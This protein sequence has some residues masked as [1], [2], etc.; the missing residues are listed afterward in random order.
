M[1]TLLRL[2]GLRFTTGHAL[3]AAALIPACLAVFMQLGRMWIGVTVAVIIAMAALLTIRGRRLT[4]WIAALFSWRRRHRQVPNVPSEPAVGATVIPGDHVAVRWQGDH[5]V[6][7]IE[8][9]PRPFTP[10]VIVNGEA[11]TDD[12]VDTRLVEDLIAAHCPDLEADVVSAGYRVGKTA[13]ASLV[14]LY[15]QVVGPY[16]APANRRTWIVLRAD[17]DQ[18]RKSAL[19]RETG[20]AGLARYLVASTTRIADHLASNGIDARCARSFDD[21]DR[22]TEISFEREMWSAIKGR[23]TFTAAYSAPGGPDVWWSARADHTITQVR[24]RPGVAPTTTVL[25]TTLANPTTPRGFSC[26][27]GGQRAAMQGQSPVTD[28]HYELPIGSAGV[29]VGETADRY[30]V[31]MPF[32]DVDVSINL[33]DARLFTQF[34]VRSA[35]SGAVVTLGP[36]FREFAGFI[37]ARIGQVAK[38]VW[39]NSTTYL[40]PHPGIGRVVLRHNF[41]DTPRHRQLPIRLIN[42]REESRY[43]MALEQ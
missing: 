33:G 43:Q 23:S 36:Q 18:T 42:P 34:V 17:P 25:L 38:V 30:P 15:E 8:L 32:D 13:P 11:F 29:L 2:F 39:P 16:P 28:R 3:W 26:L 6:S 20:V 4:G 19:R 7:V 37:N 14:A 5:L 21:F 24:I 27:F 10:T 12:V 22:A 9:V 31:Y 35:A 1:K 41:I 40:G